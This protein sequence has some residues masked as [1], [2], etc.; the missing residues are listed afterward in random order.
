MKAL[1]TSSLPRQSLVF[2]TDIVP[3]VMAV[4]S[5]HCMLFT[6]AMMM[7]SSDP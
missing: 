2:T 1:L 7:T 6:Y 4:G 3:Y 5:A